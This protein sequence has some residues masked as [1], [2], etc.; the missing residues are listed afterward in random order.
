MLQHASPFG[1]LHELAF[2]VSCSPCSLFA[3][4]LHLRAVPA[5]ADRAL[6]A[7][8]L[9]DGQENLSRVKVAFWPAI[10]RL[11]YPLPLVDRDQHRDRFELLLG[12]LSAQAGGVAFVA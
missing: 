1:L 11:V 2:S 3:R 12:R 7:D 10:F 5:A 4:M 8:G 6:V 9:R